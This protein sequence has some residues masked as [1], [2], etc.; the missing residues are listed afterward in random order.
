MTHG[1]VAT[2]YAHLSEFDV[3]A[4]DHVGLGDQVARRGNTGNSTGPHLHF[5]V[6]VHGT[7]RDPAPFLLP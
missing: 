1:T 5:E 7:P 4:G 3:S 6:R 2:R